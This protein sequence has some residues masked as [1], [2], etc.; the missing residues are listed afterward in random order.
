MGDDGSH[1]DHEN[2]TF[3]DTTDDRDYDTVSR[4]KSVDVE[5][6]LQVGASLIPSVVKQE[7]EKEEE[8][9]EEA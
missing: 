9:V 3:G 6:K 1:E 5:A 7:E 4:K 2:H 8:E